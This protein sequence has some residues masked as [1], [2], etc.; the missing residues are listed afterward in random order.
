M[1]TLKRATIL[2][3]ATAATA[4]FAQPVLSATCS[5]ALAG[6]AGSCP[7]IA[8]SIIAQSSAVHVIKIDRRELALGD[9]RAGLGNRQEIRNH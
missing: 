3:A 1:T 5:R 9:Q 6:S 2:A 8:C 7:A 4:L